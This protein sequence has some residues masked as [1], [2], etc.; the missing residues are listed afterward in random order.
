MSGEMLQRE[1]DDLEHRYC[2]TDDAVFV[3]LDYGTSKIGVAIGQL[4]T[5]TASVQAPIPNQ[6]LN[7]K[8]SCFERL[9]A[10][11]YPQAWV[12]GVPLQ[13]DGS[14]STVTRLARRFIELL[15]QRF[16]VPVY[17]ADEQLT[18]QEA[19]RRIYGNFGGRGFRTCSVDSVAAKLILEAWMQRVLYER[20]ADYS[21][22]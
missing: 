3:G 2:F 22:D 4:L 9:Y 5:G 20:N 21:A 14:R 10:E 19:K 12:V 7:V 17:D 16:K 13:L 6:R 1:K 11:W 15:R 8:W 18:T